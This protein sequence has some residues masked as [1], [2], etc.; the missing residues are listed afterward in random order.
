MKFTFSPLSVLAV[1]LG[2]LQPACASNGESTT[3]ETSTDSSTAAAMM[4]MDNTP[5]PMDTTQTMPGFTKTASG[6]QIKI[7]EP[8]GT[9]PQANP[10][11][12]V[13]VHYVGTLM[14]GKK[15]DSSRDRGQPF[16]FKLGA[17]QVIRG[18][19]EGIAMLRVGDKA[20]LIIPPALGYGERGQGSIPANSTLKF[21]V[22][23]MGVAAAPPPPKPFDISSVK[24]QKGENGLTYYV[25]K[26]NPSGTKV[27]AGKTVSVHYTGYFKDGKV[28][29][30][31]VERGEPI[32]IT[33]GKGQVIPGW[34]QGLQNLR[35]GEK[36]RLVIPY[37]L[38]YGEQGYPGAIP[39]KTDLIFDVEIVDVK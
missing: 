17:G 25:T 5:S 11:D 28:F 8:R 6:L 34:D 12:K 9:G 38:A 33:V 16:E 2:L 26:P 23:L 4:A 3:S 39:P 19:D 27:D 20:T 31:S 13:K 21:E 22:E 7:E 18:W 14:D 35:K 32:T 1:S 15:F 30:S 24:E 36:A 10:G 29:D 37:A